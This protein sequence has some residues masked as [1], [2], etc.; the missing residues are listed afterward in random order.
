M[1]TVKAQGTLGFEASATDDGGVVIASI[2]TDRGKER[3]YAFSVDDIPQVVA[4]L[5]AA[6]FD[7][8]RPTTPLPPTIVADTSVI[9]IDHATKRITL[10]LMP[11]A[12]LH[13]AFNIT[14]DHAAKIAE[15]LTKAIAELQP[16]TRH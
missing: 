12:R 1:A 15:G 7:A 3:R 11:T 16:T 14:P 13:V 5:A 4:K 2:R 8:C 6:H 9:A 10:S